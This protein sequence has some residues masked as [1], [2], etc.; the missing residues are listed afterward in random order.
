[1]R[2][3]HQNGLRPSQTGEPR[4]R[5]KGPCRTQLYGIHP[6][7]PH[8][9]VQR[10]SH[11]STAEPSMYY[12]CPH[13]NDVAKLRR[14]V[15]LHRHVQC[16]S[17]TPISNTYT[18]LYLLLITFSEQNLRISSTQTVLPPLRYCLPCASPQILTP[19]LLHFINNCTKSWLYSIS[20]P[21]L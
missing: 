6:L 12:W 2:P 16:W 19:P 1:V 20:T 3:T 11:L 17:S 4:Q 14:L 21:T 8:S 18:N 7:A 13:T 15:R 5:P 10:F 9:Y